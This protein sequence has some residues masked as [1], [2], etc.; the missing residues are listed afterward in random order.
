MRKGLVALLTAGLLL[1]G[2]SPVWAAGQAMAAVPAQQDEVV[3]VVVPGG[4]NLSDFDLSQI[5]GE[6]P[7]V[8]FIVSR[9]ASVVI[10]IV[11]GV[12][13]NA[14]YDHYFKPKPEP[15]KCK[16]ECSCEATCSDE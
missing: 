7:V 11:I 13:G 14:I 8:A 12:A 1:L 2:V 15:R 16:C 3:Q 9:A 10:G 6:N 4:Q 5:Q